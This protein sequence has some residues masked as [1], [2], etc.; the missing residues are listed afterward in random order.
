VRQCN[1]GVLV[2]SFEPRLA[3]CGAHVFI[4]ALCWTSPVS[5]RLTCIMPIHGQYIQT[6]LKGDLQRLP[7][8]GSYFQCIRQAWLVRYSCKACRV[9]I[10]AQLIAHV[11]NHACRA[12]LQRLH[13][14][15][16]IS[17]LLYTIY[18]LTDFIHLTV[19]LVSEDWS[20]SGI[21]QQKYPNRLKCSSSWP[22]D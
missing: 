22:L 1:V 8:A 21:D 3:S 10:A 6:L 9:H 16:L 13:P 20:G 14:L 15:P 12:Y 17:I 11:H 4:H 19:S 18:T 5:L 7:W 2:A